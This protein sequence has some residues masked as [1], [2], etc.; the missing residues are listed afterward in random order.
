MS[1]V[2][3]EE[4]IMCAICVIPLLIVGVGVLHLLLSGDPCEEVGE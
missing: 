4:L 2:Q 3:V 1:S